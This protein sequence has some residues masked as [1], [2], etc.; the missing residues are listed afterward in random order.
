MEN[1]CSIDPDLWFG[2]ADDDDGD[3]VA[4]NRAYEVSATEARTI[5]LRRC[6]LAQQRVCAQRAVDQQEEFGVWAGVKLPGNQYR[7][8]SDLARAHDILRRIAR[9]ELNP[10]EL[11]ENAALLSRGENS[12]S[13]RCSVLALAARPVVHPSAA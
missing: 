7:K 4:K 3:N 12:T 10:R 9:G 5:C 6:P 1:P 8:R 2:Y 13:S 11:P